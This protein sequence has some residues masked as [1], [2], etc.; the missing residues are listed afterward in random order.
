MDA[1][2]WDDRYQA[3]DRLW[4]ASPNLFVA[5]R[6]A[7]TSPGVGLDLASGEGRNSIWLAD[8]G[9]SMTAVDFSEVAVERGRRMSSEVEF[10]VADVLSWEPDRSF[11]LVLLA[12]LQ[13]VESDLLLVVE[14]SITW[15][16]PGG[17]IFFIGHDR[18]NI[19]KGYG[20]PQAPEILWDVGTIV[21][22]LDDLEVVEAQV[23][24]RPV[25]VDGEILL[26][27]DTLVR[28]RAAPGQRGPS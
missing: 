16:V 5:D 2:E 1:N 22:W 28:A 23:V 25:E 9:W 15:L 13:L 26:A 17:E 14:R 27:R 3:A 7:S 19:E 18:S 6:L 20:G 21:S 12:Y 24:R 4:S 11:D 10:V 8:K